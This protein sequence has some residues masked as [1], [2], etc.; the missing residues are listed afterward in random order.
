MIGIIEQHPN[1]GIGWW[2]EFKHDSM[3]Y[4][5]YSVTKRGAMRQMK[6]RHNKVMKQ[7]T[8]QRVEVEL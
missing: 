5:G 1:L 8:G 7:G 6:R 4:S 2:W 3:R